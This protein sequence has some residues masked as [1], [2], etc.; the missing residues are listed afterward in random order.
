M[1]GVYRQMEPT[2]VVHEHRGLLNC[3][4]AIGAFALVIGLGLWLRECIIRRDASDYRDK[5]E[6]K[7]FIEL[8]SGPGERANS[9]CNGTLTDQGTGRD[10]SLACHCNGVKK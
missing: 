1:S 6:C 7:E 4:Y 10:H 9:V 8:I 5:T 3:V 2:I